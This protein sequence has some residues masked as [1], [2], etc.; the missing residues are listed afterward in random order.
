MRTEKPARLL[1]ILMKISRPFLSEKNRTG[2]WLFLIPE[3]TGL[4]AAEDVLEATAEETAAIITFFRL[5][6]QRHNKNILKT[7]YNIAA[8]LRILFQTFTVQ[9][10]QENE[11]NKNDFP[12]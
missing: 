7:F 6:I 4:W 5:F 2:K 12:L 1:L 8:F 3:A 9:L 10:D 11:G